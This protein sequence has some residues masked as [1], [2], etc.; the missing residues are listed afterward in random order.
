MRHDRAE[1]ERLVAPDFC[2]ITS[3]PGNPATR[4]EWIAAAT[5]AFE[6]TTYALHHLQ[7]IHAAEAAVVVHRLT[8][9]AR[10]GSRQAARNWLIS[11]V[12]T[13]TGGRWQILTRHAE[14]LPD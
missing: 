3:R 5:G 13:G 4:A 9:Q 7:T 12:W 6:V 10:L 8:Q 2:L 11:D 14:A 1:L